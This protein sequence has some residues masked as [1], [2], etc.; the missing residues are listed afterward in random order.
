M[1]AAQEPEATPLLL[2]EAAGGVVTTK[3]LLE[4]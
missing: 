2:A 3:D 4:E 1:L